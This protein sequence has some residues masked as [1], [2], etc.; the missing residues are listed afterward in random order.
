MPEIQIRPAEPVDYPFLAAINH[1]YESYYVWQMD[2]SIEA[3][4]VNIHYR[5]V[6]LPRAVKVDYPR[7]SKVLV[8]SW[9]NRIAVLVAVMGQQPV[10]YLSISDHLAIKT[11]WISDMAVHEGLRR[12]GIGTALLLAGQEWAIDHHFRRIVIEMQSKN[13]GAIQM[14]RKNGFEF[15]G[16]ND[17][18]YSNQDIALFF[19]RFLR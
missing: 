3:G 12:K 9:A 18:Y 6:R 17:Y 7:S 10:G 19:G 15:C 13:F 4:I 1:S 14:V 8:D 2:R 5:E 11:A 16:Y